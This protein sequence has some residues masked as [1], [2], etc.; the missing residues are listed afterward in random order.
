QILANLEHPNIARL[1]EG[2]T[3][4]DDQP[5]FVLEYVEGVAIDRFCDQRG[6]SVRQRIELFLKVG[7]AVQF[8]HRNLVV[9]RDLKPSNILVTEGGEPKLLDFGISKVLDP[10][11][12]TADTMTWMAPRALTP[13][14]A[15]PEQALGKPVTTASDVYSLGI[16]L[17][18]LLSGSRPYRW[19][20]GLR[21]EE[22]IQRVICTQ[23]PPRPSSM[24]KEGS[25][26]EEI[27]R[28]RRTSPSRLR[29]QLQGDLDTIILMAIRKE[30]ERRYT[31]VEQL[32]EDLRRH[33]D[34]VPVRAHRSTFG[35]RAGKLLKRRKKELAALSAAGLL[36]VGV[37]VDRSILQ[38]DAVRERDR[39]QRVSEFL[40]EIFQV[41]DPGEA[42]G[43]TVTAREIL[44]RGATRIG[45]ELE[46]A[47][48]L[49]AT[50]MMTISK[51]YQNLGLLEEATGLAEEALALRRQELGDRHLEVA[52]SL[53]AV[54]DLLFLQDRD[55]ERAKSLRERVL[56]IR[57]ELL[58]PGDPLISETL[59]DL[60][61]VLRQQ[62]RLDESE[63]LLRRAL[64]YR[65]A[66]K[67]E[68]NLEL[69]IVNNLATLLQDQ[70]RYEEAE[71]LFRQALEAKRRLLGE[72]HP[73]V[74]RALNNLALLLLHRKAFD[75]AEEMLGEALA[76][77][78]KCF[79]DEHL[80]VAL[81][82]SN[83]GTLYRDRRELDRAEAAFRESLA[84]RRKVL[85]PDSPYIARALKHLAELQL[86]RGQP[87]AAEDSIR[88]SLA[89]LRKTQPE[90]HWRISDANGVLGSV[91]AAQGRY[92][93]AEPL[94]LTG[95]ASTRDLRGDKAV[96]TIEARERLVSLYLQSG[97]LARAERYRTP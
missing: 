66:R 85:E 75:E 81:T 50:L 62:G 83:L 44:D 92:A 86:L 13:E 45:A 2:G 60:A 7:E 72:D 90:N 3:T 36:L 27:S 88:E 32:L 35:Y 16:L 76:V 78:R 58:K 63:A 26:G 8:A 28:A 93:E 10:V 84:I 37:A 23:T 43:N 20:E 9:H 97:D 29:R 68:E 25:A 42:R 80:F 51:V 39:A 48:Q 46:D 79:G 41:S 67:G 21:T 19:T 71:P 38:Q 56:S 61:L 57:E 47:P 1:H 96:E 73:S 31:S 33:L 77:A 40:V 30:P 70:G 5:Y 4:E 89:I 94:L 14:Y 65:P 34:G 74:A 49:R 11:T 69:Q 6:F 15:S 53:S 22:D 17:F 12:R 59:N 87:S 52:E 54:A 82:L 91:L 55:P 95:L 64:S 24:V 18:E